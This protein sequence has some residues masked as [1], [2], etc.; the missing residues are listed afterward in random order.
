MKHILS[1]KLM[2]YPLGRIICLV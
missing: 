2:I 1:H